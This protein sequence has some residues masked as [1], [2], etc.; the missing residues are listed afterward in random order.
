MFPLTLLVVEPGTADEP[1][2]A[3]TPIGMDKAGG[4][5]LINSIDHLW[6]T[7]KAQ[8]GAKAGTREGGEK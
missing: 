1:Y 8:A 3:T 2:T 6:L 7:I 4:G 5:R